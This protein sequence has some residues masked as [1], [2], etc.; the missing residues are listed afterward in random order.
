M[1]SVYNL[2]YF[3]DNLRKIRKNNRLTQKQVK[4]IS[5]INE[6]TLRRIENGLVIP[7][8]ETL[9]ILSHVYKENL[10]HILNE[11]MKQNQI[12]IFYNQFDNLINCYNLED[13]KT[14]M[15]KL[16]NTLSDFTS[17]NS[18]EPTD[19]AQLKAFVSCTSKYFNNNTNIKVLIQ[20]L[21]SS[22]K[23][24]LINFDLANFSKY[25]YNS[26]EIRCLLLIGLLLIKDKN[27]LKSLEVLKFC[28][29]YLIN[30]NVKSLDSKKVLIKL[31]FNISYN[32]HIIDNHYEALKYANIGIQYSLSQHLIY[33]LSHLYFRKGIA[34]MY[35]DIKTFKTSLIKSIE[36]FLIQDDIESAKLYYKV[37]LSQYKIDLDSSISY[38]DILK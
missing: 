31:Y 24:S 35:S 13:I 11:S 22:I 4:N 9:K 10:L 37:L 29:T 32:Y 7:K 3:G 27:I 33:C 36:L 14:A 16:E 15:C 20:S 1:F 21:E 30:Q 34:E 17:L 5:G 28:L 23:L 6:E 12:S 2:E 19:I 25:N 38:S 18:L 8:Y 26:L